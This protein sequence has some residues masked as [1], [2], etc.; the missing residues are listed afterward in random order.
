[1][2]QLGG[3]AKLTLYLERGH[4]ICDL[5]YRQPELFTWLLKQKRGHSE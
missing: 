1:M 4:G 3:Q 5:V 2:S